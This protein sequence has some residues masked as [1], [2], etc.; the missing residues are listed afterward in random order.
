M[1]YKTGVDKFQTILLPDCLGDYV[2][3]NHICRVIDAFVE[4]IDMSE[5][6][7]KYATPA[8]TGCRPYS[9][10]M[11]LKL[12]IYGFMNRVRSSRRLE[13]ETQRNIE[14]MWLMDKLTPDDKTICNFRRDNAK[15]IKSAFRVFSK[16]CNDWGL[17]GKEVVAVD[18]TKI[19]AN[20]S[21]KNNH[22][23]TTVKRKLNLLDKR[24]AEY[25]T[26]LDENDK[27]DEKEI[28][29]NEVN[30]KE[31]LEILNGKKDKLECLLSQIE[32]N[33]GTEVSTIDKDAR[34]MKQGGNAGLDVCYN[35]QS[36][37]DSKNGL[38]VDIDVINSSVDRG[39]LF[40]MT[41]KA[42]E[43]MEAEE[44]TALA[45]RGYYE[46]ADIVK[47]EGEGTNCLVSKPDAAHR[48]DDKNY[49]RDKFIY[50]YETD[51]YICPENT[52]LKYM[53]DQ[54]IKGIKYRVYAN[55]GACRVCPNKD[56]C[57][58]SKQGRQIMR[59]EYQDIMDV[60]DNR[61]KVN[62]KLYK[63]RQHIV[64]APFGTIKEI[65]GYSNFLCR[66][67]E[68][69]T[70]E[71]CLAFLAYNLRRVINIMGTSKLIAVLK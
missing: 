60:V 10:K 67:L 66:G 65:W 27:A 19:R 21:R 51:Q 24:I 62:N 49:F 38:I 71:A 45:D 17:Y 55:Y 28:K 11:M 22:N 25:M 36:V 32:A 26:T 58:K 53:R 44:I 7:F 48:V 37:V 16:L 20:N 6:D 13:A 63:T 40:S 47:C 70:G 46:S 43:I 64:E 68:K 61:T 1:S 18:G 15:A 41:E 42:K 8:D 54:N 14:V 69:V 23:L 5:L 33:N 59:S 39:E 31:I 30:I 52:L 57:T 34:L 29:P 2:S 9:P 3:E 4:Q 12:Y 35:V 56:K 50:N